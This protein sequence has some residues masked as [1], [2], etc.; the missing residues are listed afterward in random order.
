MTKKKDRRRD[1]HN[2]RKKAFFSKK[3][4]KAGLLFLGALCVG[5]I[6][7]AAILVYHGALRYFFF[8]D[9]FTSLWIAREAPRTFWR[10]LSSFVY[11]RAVGTLFGLNSVAF[12]VSSLLFHVANGVLV[13]LIARA[14]SVSRVTSIM[15]AIL[16]A[17]HPALYTAIYTISST[18]EILSCFFVLAAS[19]YLMKARRPEGVGVIPVVCVLFAASL[20]SK[21]TT[22]AFP[23]LAILVFKARGI[24]T[25]KAIPVFATL[26]AVAVAYAAFFYA[27]DVFG[28]RSLSSKLFT[29][30]KGSS[31]GSA[32][33]ATFGM[34]LVTSLQTYFK[35]TFDIFE[36]WRRFQFNVL[37][38]RALPWLF[39]GLIVFVLLLRQRGAARWK[40]LYSV[41]WFILMLLPVVPLT[42]HPYHY[43]LYVPLAGLCPALGLYLSRLL[44]QS[45]GES[46]VSACIVVFFVVNSALLMAKTEQR[47][48]STSARIKESILDRP[49]ISGNLV[50]DVR[51]MNL[52]QGTKLVLVSPLRDIREGRINE[53]PFLVMGGS[54]W[55]TN[56]R[57]AIAEG[58]GLR[59]FFPQ[60]DSVAF[61]DTLTPQYEDYFAVGY[62]WDGHLRRDTMRPPSASARPVTPHAFSPG[63]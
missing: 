24:S 13:F 46:L 27:S 18:G 1:R 6:A 11:F 30:E 60:I 10:I 15:S 26:L 20:L 4:G 16:F 62:T 7:L 54:Y 57:A 17:V 39:A 52:P 14:F 23:F 33:A 35:W 44:R 2:S 40:S 21:E 55:D 22:I 28:V 47:T 51:D 32:Y 37:D 3:P 34:G 5:S 31:E 38:Q 42:S 25:R 43:Y 12:H 63:R 56:L 45:R 8:Q 58:L 29:A 48:V 61:A 9:D 49:I 36:Q 59:L 19:L 50:S 41:A 53:H